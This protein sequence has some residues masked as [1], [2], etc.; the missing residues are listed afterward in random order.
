MANRMNVPQ[1]KV[2]RMARMVEKVLDGDRIAR[3]Q[4]V[5]S[6]STSDA[7][8]ALVQVFNYSLNNQYA[9]LPRIADEF[10][11]TVTVGDF[12]NVRFIDILPDF[13]G[14][15]QTGT[16]PA[17]T[18][19]VIPELSQYP[20]VS[21]T[22]SETFIKANKIGAKFGYSWEEQKE[23][24]IGFLADFPNQIAI[25]ARNT[26]D[27]TVTAAFTGAVTSASQLTAGTSP[28]DNTTTF[29]HNGA[30]SI[31]SLAAAI[32]QVSQR[33][34]AGRFVVVNDFVL[35]VPPTLK[36]LANQILQA[37]DYRITDG[38]I[39]YT[40]AAASFGNVTLVV[41]PWLTSN[42]AWYL[43]PKPGTSARKAIIQTVMA[44]EE[45]PEIR[46]AGLNGGYYPGGGD[47]PWSE[48]SFDNDS[49][50]FRLRHVTGGGLVTEEGIVWSLGDNS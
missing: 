38:S 10:S 42:T 50:D 14:L 40:T 1:D 2:D 6:I 3:A 28:I 4:F 30:L 7:P 35:V 22:S 17:Y 31:H 41:D 36:Y 23:D 46:V 8:L 11:T 18:L 9:E 43:V 25:A 27:Y 12:R 19:P 24:P 21:I 33:K 13:S 29:T 26:V 34:F 16:Q 37:T 49:I 48:G 39:K 45:T 20:Y 44:G 32:F 47:V 5:E 15:A